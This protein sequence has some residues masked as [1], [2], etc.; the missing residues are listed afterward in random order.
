MNVKVEDQTSELLE[1]FLQQFYSGTPVIQGK[2]SSRRISR[3][4]RCWNSG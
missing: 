1:R 4:R 3:I 2:F